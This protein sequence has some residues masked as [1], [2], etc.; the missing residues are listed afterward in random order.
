MTKTGKKAIYNKWKSCILI[1]VFILMII[2]I[3]VHA[4]V[5]KVDVTGLATGDET[6]HDCSKYLETKYNGTKHWEQCSISNCN[7]TFNIDTHSYYD[8]WTLGDSC[9]PNNKHVFTC[10]CGYSY[11]TSNIR[12]HGNYKHVY[13][14]NI[15]KLSC[16]NCGVAV[17]DTEYHKNSSG[18]T[19]G[20]T[21]GISGT[22]AICGVTSSLT[23]TGDIS[24]NT[25]N[26]KISGNGGCRGCGYQIWNTSVS[27]ATVT[28]NGNNF[29]ITAK[30]VYNSNVTIKSIGTPYFAGSA[31]G[32]ITNSNYTI[33]SNYIVYTISGYFNSGNEANL[34]ISFG[35]NASMNGANVSGNMYIY[36]YPEKTAPTINTPTQTNVSTSSDGWATNKQLTFTG[37]ENYCGSVK[38]TLKDSSGNVYLNNVS[39]NVN[40][41]SWSYSCTPNIEA[42]ANGKTF[43]LTATDTL[44]NSS[45]KSFTVYK[46]DKKSPLM[47]SGTTTTTEWSK[48]KA[49]KVIGTDGGSGKLAIAFNNTNRYATANVSGSTYSR[50]YVLTGDVYGNVTA[51]IYLKDGVGNTTT[52]FIT[53]YN[54]DNTKPKITNISNST[55]VGYANT[56]I[57]A[58]DENAVLK[59]KGKNYIGSGVD[60]Y[61]VTK[62]EKQPVLSEFQSASTIKILESGTYYFWVKD[63]VGNIST[64]QKKTVNVKYKLAL[65]YNKPNNASAELKGNSTQSLQ[66]T[67]N[68][69]IGS[70][71][72]PS[73]IGWKFMGWY[74]DNVEI[75]DSTIWKYNESKK[76]IAKWEPVEY[77]VNFNGNFN[78]NTEQQSYI[79]RFV[80][81][82]KQNI[83]ENKFTRLDTTLYDN[84]MYIKGYEFLGWN[85]TADSYMEEFKDKQEILNLTTKDNNTIDFFAIW[86][87]E[88]SLTFNLNG[89]KYKDSSDDIILS[90]KIYNNQFNYTFDIT[91]GKTTVNLPKYTEQSNEI[92][93]YGTTI[94]NG[95]NNSYR[96]VNTDGTEYRFLG[97]STNPNA[98]VSDID[99]CVYNPDRKTTVTISDDTTL[100][101]VWEPVLNVDFIIQRTL[102]TL[103]QVL[104]SKVVAD[105]TTPNPEL[106]LVIKPGEQAKYE[107]F[108]KG[109]A[110]YINVDFDERI[111]KIY[112]NKGTWTDDL[113][114]NPSTLTTTV[115]GI[116]ASAKH[117]LNR[118]INLD[119][120][121]Y[122]NKNFYIPQYLGTTQSE[123]SSIGINTYT[124]DF[125]ITNKDSFYYKYVLGKAEG[126]QVKI[127]AYIYLPTETEGEEIKIPSV[128][129]ELRTRLKI[130]LH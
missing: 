15:H 10:S 79:Q 20:C 114:P 90:A 73:L 97:W 102:G 63:S 130:R 124:A 39:V 12:N 85:R 18:Q 35:T 67:Y 19:I 83:L 86:Q 56:T 4:E 128:L 3:N 28:Y 13:D 104:P 65:D 46:T 113:N 95:L 93:A 41:K 61:A 66:T 52:K 27:S 1:S 24:Y 58:H 54:L 33:Y 112:D 48:T 69:A 31:T 80:Y 23:H 45:S 9:N 21:T 125:A 62:T 116:D 38:L 89:G 47:T 117:G 105:A 100:Y 30:A 96:K 76:A 17:S 64:P 7:R 74:I 40:N 55:G 108:V 25:V 91:G 121:G 126:E 123:P 107:L 84:V 5:T 49:Y 109:N 94:N 87:K 68:S 106:A 98:K 122:I 92:N 81:D 8:Y 110:D 11:Q 16:G 111:T 37:T 34:P 60:G 22:C 36:L 43:T 6:S 29:T 75:T 14:G 103:N 44:G 50:D 120:L 42:D 51:A 82:V 53:V 26:N 88:L 32:T 57:T 77:T 70:M 127:R 71:P 2:K 78:W 99:L 119:G 115:D 101:A 118:V 129:D 59:A 72:I